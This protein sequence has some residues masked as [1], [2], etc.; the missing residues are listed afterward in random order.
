MTTATQTDPFAPGQAFTPGRAKTATDFLMGGGTLSCQFPT[1]GTE[2]AGTI[3]EMSVEVQ[4]DYDD[5]SKVLTW[6]DGT[7]RQQLRVVLE[8][9]GYTK[10]YDG[11]TEEW[12][13]TDDTDDGSRAL[14]VKGQMAKAFRDAVRKSGAKEPEVGGYLKVTY[15]TNGQRK[16][17]SRGK[18]PK[19]YAVEYLPPS[20]NPK[21]AG[22]FLAGGEG[23]GAPN[24]FGD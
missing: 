23:G 9:T 16:E 2:Y 13:D 1:K 7:A 18:P 22:D 15:V 10:K 5:P 21:A 17:G 11:D 6:N 19:N 12:V 14:Y 20:K 8:G 3:T 24:P 4:R